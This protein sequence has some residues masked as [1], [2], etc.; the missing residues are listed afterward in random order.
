MSA[1]T[2]RANCTND[3]AAQTGSAGL[4]NTGG[5][6]GGSGNATNSSPAGAGGSG[7]VIIRYTMILNS[8]ATISI[9]GGSLI[10]RTAKNISVTTSGAGKVDFKANGKYIGGCRNIASTAGNSYTAICAYRPSARGQVNISAIFKPSDSGFIG[11][12]ALLPA[13]FVINRAGN[14]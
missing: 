2:C 14:R 5:G 9:A 8:T 7:V 13:V 4:A 1:A 11:T 12:S 6:G 3:T 10:Y